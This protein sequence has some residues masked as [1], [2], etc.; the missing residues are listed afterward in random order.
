MAA[1][2]EAESSAKFVFK[3]TVR[4][5]GAAT[6]PGLEGEKDMVVVRV[7]QIVRAPDALSDFTGRDITVQLASGETVTKGEQA[8]FY[9]NGWLF[10][11]SVAVKSLAHRPAKDVR[12]VSAKAVAADPTDNLKRHELE[13][14]IDSADVVVSGT[15]TK[16]SVVPSGPAASTKKFAVATT[17]D[18]PHQPI[19]EHDPMW[20]EATVRVDAVH[21]G[22]H[23]KKTVMVRFPSSSDVKWH[24]AVKLHPGQ[25]GFFILH[26]GEGQRTRRA[27]AIAAGLTGATEEK[28]QAYTALHPLDF[29]P[30]DVD[31]S[32]KDLI[33]GNKP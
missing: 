7:D 22:R 29:Q 20:R 11:D 27:K 12:A 6:L 5:L 31:S 8:V 30:F 15:V 23:G 21:K 14:R 4:R 2:A 26:K 33:T 32:I 13:S 9:T 16:V 25:E 1:N 28:G 3:G 10:G 18:A 19:S 17:G 24:K